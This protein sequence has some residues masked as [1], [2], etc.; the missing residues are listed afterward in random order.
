[1]WAGATCLCAV[2]SNRCAVSGFHL[3]IVYSGFDAL[4]LLYRDMFG[5]FGF[6][7]G[8]DLR[9]DLRGG[10][11]VCCGL[12]RSRSGGCFRCGL[13]TGEGEKCKE[14]HD[15]FLWGVRSW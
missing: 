14:Y 4:V 13:G 12:S 7:L 10:L 3:A 2:G 1:M 9:F 8:F 11:G 5:G 6:D 15:D